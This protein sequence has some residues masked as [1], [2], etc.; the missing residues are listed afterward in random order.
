MLA[1][2]FLVG[3]VLAAMGGAFPGASNLAV[4]QATVAG[5]SQQGKQI[6][7]G[8]GF[9]EITLAFLALYYSM[10]VT[11]FLVMNPWVKTAFVLVFLVVGGL[12]LVKHRLPKKQLRATSN[13]NLG[14]RLLK[15]YALAALNPPVLL[16]WLIAIALVHNNYFELS[17]TLGTSELALFFAGVFSG[18]IAILMLYGST[19]RRLLQKKAHRGNKAI[20]TFIG[21]ALISIS[22]VQGIRL[23][24]I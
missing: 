22:L 19:G 17:A 6:A 20:N 1:L 4:I 12:F 15:G 23:L 13:S 11:D 18:K 16:F 2:Y 5:K 24:I 3:S 8:A 14:H 10:M 21:I 9:G 7:F